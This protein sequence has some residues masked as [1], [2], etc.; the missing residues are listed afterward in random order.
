MDAPRW[1]GRWQLPAGRLEGNE[2]IDEAIKRELIEEVSHAPESP[3]FLGLLKQK[4]SKAK[5][6][7]WAAVEYEEAALFQHSDLSAAG[8][9]EG[10]DARFWPLDAVVDWS[11]DQLTPGTAH[12]LKTYGNTITSHSLGHTI[13]TASEL[14]L[15]T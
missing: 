7:Y 11:D 10:M 2:S 13:P 12:I 9:G 14:G 6:T 4:G 8:T 1:P 15:L 3:I 5:A